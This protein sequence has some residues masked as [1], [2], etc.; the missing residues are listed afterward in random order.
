MSRTLL[1]PLLAGL[2]VICPLQAGDKP[3]PIPAAPK[4]IFGDSSAA[5]LAPT[6]RVAISSFVVSFQASMGK[7]IQTGN[8][9]SSVAKYGLGAL[10]RHDKSEA[11]GSTIMDVDVEVERKVVTTLYQRLQKDLTE[12]GFEVVPETEVLAADAYKALIKEAAYAN[13][14]RWHDTKGDTMLVSPDTLTPYQVYTPELG[15]FYSYD[16]HSYR[17]GWI[18]TFGGSSTEGGPTPIKGSA[19]YKVPD[20][21]ASLARQLNAHVLKATYLVTIGDMDMSASHQYGMSSSDG[22]RTTDTTID[23]KTHAAVKAAMGLREGQTRL[24]FRTANGKKG[25]PYK[26]NKVPC[27]KDGDVVV[28]IDAPIQGLSDLLSLKEIGK[29]EGEI[30]VTDNAAFT[31]R[32]VDLIESQQKAMVELVKR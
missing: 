5:P 22:G 8:F 19:V 25:S 20:L 30:T 11:T 1:Y 4:A 10:L 3:S 7:T 24:A 18:K 2:T 15:D 32:L 16:L 21:E 13:Y 14:S 17:K 6:K 26:L 12:A 9:G 23:T 29:L 28:T 27:A 31:D